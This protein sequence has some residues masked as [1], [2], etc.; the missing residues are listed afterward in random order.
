MELLKRNL[1]KNISKDSKTESP[2]IVTNPGLKKNIEE[3]C[4]FDQTTQSDEFLKGI[5][6][7]EN[8]RWDSKT[9]TA[10]IVLNDHWGLSLH[11]G[12]C[13][14]FSVI[15]DFIYDKSIDFEENQDMIFDNIIWISNLLD[16]FDGEI[17]KEAIDNAKVKIEIEDNKRHIYFM[18]ERIYE[19]Y[20]MS[21]YSIEDA[22]YIHLAYRLN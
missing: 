17:I 15:A 3:D 11:R 5:K 21:F 12:G 4:I 8:Y 2:T 20:Y 9:K 16:D 18:D 1:D 14:H 19:S 10:E 13:N 22:S 6:E 7:L